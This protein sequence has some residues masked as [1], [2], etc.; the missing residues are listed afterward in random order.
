MNELTD[1]KLAEMKE[2]WKPGARLTTWKPLIDGKSVEIEVAASNDIWTL[3]TEID[4]LKVENGK[5]REE[6]Y[7]K[8]K[9]T[10]V[11]IDRQR[12][13][14]EV[15]N[16]SDQIVA[17]LKGEIEELKKDKARLDWAE[18]HKIN[19]VVSRRMGLYFDHSTCGDSLRES[20]D[21][22]ITAESEGEK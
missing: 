5:L 15:L 1:Q 3:I 13:E 7:T 2:R 18:K 8:E 10:N 21:Q 19:N 9:W 4:R 22:S 6:V 11:E 17:K 20:I 16:E 12:K 14:I